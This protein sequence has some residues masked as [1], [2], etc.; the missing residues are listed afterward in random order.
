MRFSRLDALLLVAVIAA[1]ALARSGVLE[2]GPR[3]PR[4]AVAGIPIR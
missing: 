1:I 4:D 3:L 2:P